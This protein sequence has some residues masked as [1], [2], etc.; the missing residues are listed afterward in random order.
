MTA[1]EQERANKIVP[2]LEA[3][4]SDSGTYLEEAKFRQHNW[5]RQF[6]GEKYERLF[7]I[8]EAYD[9]EGLLYATT[10]VGSEA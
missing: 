10:A 3:A 1:R 6:Y 7:A 2:A 8:K 4:I 9:P 5:Q